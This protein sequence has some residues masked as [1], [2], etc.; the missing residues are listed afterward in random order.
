MRTN[1]VIHKNEIRANYTPEKENLGLQ[2]FIATAV[3]EHLL[4]MEICVPVNIDALPNHQ[5]S[6]VTL[7]FFWDVEEHVADSR[8]PPDGPVMRLDLD[9]SVVMGR[10]H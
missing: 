5:T 9:L 4:D 3:T 8:F 6:T 2:D 1:L 7:G 10:S